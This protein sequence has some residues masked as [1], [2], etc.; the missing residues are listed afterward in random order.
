MSAGATVSNSGSAYNPVLDFSFTMEKGDKGDTGDYVDLVVSYGTSTAAATEPSTWYSSPTSLSYTAG[1]FI[2]Q[3][4][5][6]QLHDAGTVQRTEEK[7]IGYIGQNGSGS[8][9]VSQITFNGTVFADD[10]TGNV[11]MTVDADEV[12][13]IANP[14]TKSNGQ[15][16]TYDSSADEWV[17]ANPATGNV[18]T[19]NNVGVTAGTTNVQLYATSIPMSSTDG[20]S[21]KNAIPL[22]SSANPQPLGTASAGSATTWSKGDHVHPFPEYIHVGASAP[23]DSNI[24]IWLDTDDPGQST[25]S[26]VNGKSGTVL[27]DA[28]DVGAMAV[29]ELVWENAT[30]SSSFA[31]Q[32][33]PLD[34]IDYDAVWIYFARATS[35]LDDLA[36]SMVL[37]G[38]SYSHRVVSNSSSSIRYYARNATVS[39]SGVEFGACTYHTQGSSSATTENVSLVPVY[40]YGIKGVEVV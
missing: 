16:L 20:T 28:A 37:N 7:I 36:G 18:N 9:T 6:Y 13:A 15:V 17:A 38:K 31:A 1:N 8:G 30:A 11:P 2:W 12:G 32:P 5:E 24:D 26:S 14:G 4:T 35:T 10:G 22:A 40:I 33:I 27:L 21:V 19:V 23:S 34:L 25:V 39:S 3:K 29:W